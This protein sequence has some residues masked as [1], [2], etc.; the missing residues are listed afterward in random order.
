MN[1]MRRRLLALLLALLLLLAFLLAVHN[2]ETGRRNQGL[3]QLE[4]AVRRAAVACYAAEGAY[5]PNI[6]YLQA[7][8]GLQYNENEYIIH[9]QVVASN[10]MPDIT[11]LERK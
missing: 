2:L 5:P 3:Q 10:L 1:A 7:H 6:A 4:S 8:Y 11:V 9:Y